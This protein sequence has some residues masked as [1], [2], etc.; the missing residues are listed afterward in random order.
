MSRRPMKTVI[1][2]DE[3]SF[4]NDKAKS[5]FFAFFVMFSCVLPTACSIDSEIVKEKIDLPEHWALT[6]Q[7]KSSLVNWWKDCN[8]PKLNKL[9]DHV[10]LKNADLELAIA[11]VDESRA[12]LGQS[13]AEQYPALSANIG[14]LKANKLSLPFIGNDGFTQYGFSPFLSYE[15][16]L[17]G[18]LAKA[19]EAARFQLLSEKEN[20]RTIRLNII[21]E[22]VRCYFS[23]LALNAQI[24]ETQR[25]ILNR[26]NAYV[27]H[28]KLFS[29]G[30]INEVVLRQSQ[31]SYENARLQK[32]ALEE[33]KQIYIN[34]IHILSGA[35]PSDMFDKSMY[36]YEGLVLPKLPSLPNLSPEQVVC[37]RPDILH[38]EHL[39]SASHAY[40]S[41]ARAAYLPKLSLWGLLG[42]H[43][44]IFGNVFEKGPA[45]AMA[46]SLGGPIFDFGRTRSIVEA[47]EA[48]QRQAY[49]A[50][51][52]TIRIAFREIMDALAGHK[53]NAERMSIQEKK[54]DSV[55]RM[56]DLSTLR[57]RDGASS[58]LDVLASELLIFEETLR[59]I[60]INFDQ[61]ISSVNLYKALGG[62]CEETASMSKS[63]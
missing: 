38:A 13:N 43:S 26:E 14:A 49:I 55:R 4:K 2:Q 20:I 1:K 18:R 44:D 16:D 21:A 33:R 48:R 35:S 3:I 29:K 32:P 31:F 53:S 17:W 7:T 56:H 39:L 19:T 10:L 40:V 47:S 5:K 6:G 51:K 52:Q 8:D 58:Y 22:T 37:G 15:I 45:S 57:F 30:F 36:E 34:A 59:K 62:A 46:G 54:V 28:K 63:S 61:M 12:L 9:I 23:I 11:R 42:F 27:L 60:N 25:I 50:Y 41:V 24:S